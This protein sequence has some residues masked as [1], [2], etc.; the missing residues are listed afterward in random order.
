MDVQQLQYNINY[1]VSILTLQLFYTFCFWRFNL[2]LFWIQVRSMHRNWPF[3][4]IKPFCISLFIIFF[5]NKNNTTDSFLG[6]CPRVPYD[7][8]F[9]IVPHFCYLTSFSVSFISHAITRSRG[10]ITLIFNTEQGRRVKYI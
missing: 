7:L 1:P 3:D 2:I 8:N 9:L 5:N 4:S 10:L 6:V